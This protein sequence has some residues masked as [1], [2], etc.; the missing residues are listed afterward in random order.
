MQNDYATENVK[1]RQHMMVNKSVHFDSHLLFS[2]FTDPHPDEYDNNDD[3][4]LHSSTRPNFL[5]FLLFTICMA[6]VVFWMFVFAS[7]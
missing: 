7:T 3:H 1:Q 4:D 5:E 2:L 6:S